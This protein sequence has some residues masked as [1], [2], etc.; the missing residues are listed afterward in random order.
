MAFVWAG[1]GGMT[2]RANCASNELTTP[3]LGARTDEVTARDTLVGNCDCDGE[4]FV[5]EFCSNCL[6]KTFCESSDF[7]CGTIVMLDILQLSLIDISFDASF[8]T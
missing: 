4:L 1:T 3:R 6:S 8:D 2:G 7:V 5:P